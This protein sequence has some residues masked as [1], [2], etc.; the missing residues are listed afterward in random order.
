M[1]GQNLSE[2]G[3]AAAQEQHVRNCLDGNSGPSATQAGKYVVYRVRLVCEQGIM[4]ESYNDYHSL[5]T[6]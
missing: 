2:L 3:P 5:V 1:C 6:R 4:I